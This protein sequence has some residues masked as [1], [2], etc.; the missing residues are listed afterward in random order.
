MVTSLVALL[1]YLLV[2]GVVIWLALY[3]I[4]V[5]PL[6]E[7][8]GRVARVVIVVIGCLILIMLLLGMVDGVRMPIAL[9]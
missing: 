4:S 1:I 2:I 8:F 6:P 3:I 5:I 7:P 9:R